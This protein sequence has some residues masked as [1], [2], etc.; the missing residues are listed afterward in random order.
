[1]RLIGITA[2]RFGHAAGQ[3]D[4][5]AQPEREKQRRVDEAADRIVSRFGKDAARRGGAMGH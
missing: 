2:E 1:M 3:M 5:V 4:L